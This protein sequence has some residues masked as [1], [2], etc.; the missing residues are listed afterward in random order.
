MNLHI[1]RQ[2]TASRPGDEHVDAARAPTPSAADAGIGDVFSAE[3]FF[4]EGFFV[5][6]GDGAKGHALAQQAVACR[7]AVASALDG[8][9]LQAQRPGSGPVGMQDEPWA[10]A[11]TTPGAV[12]KEVAGQ[13]ESLHAA[14]RSALGGAAHR[15]GDEMQHSWPR[16]VE[17]GVEF[18]LRKMTSVA[19]QQLGPGL[20]PQIA[21]EAA[22]L[23]LPWVMSGV[24][25]VGMAMRS[26]IEGLLARPAPPPSQAP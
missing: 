17:K 11:P 25:H 16:L 7:Q 20:E 5:T 12:A 26:H 9:L 3:R 1:Q 6:V 10:A 21:E 2:A 4:P 19:F 14:L 8:A 24:V 18:G 15:V 23:V 13:E 22:K